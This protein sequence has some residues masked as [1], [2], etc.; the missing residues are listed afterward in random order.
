MKLT[1]DRP[2]T[3][4]QIEVLQIMADKRGTSFGIISYM[5]RSGY[6]KHGIRLA[7][8]TVYSLMK[9]GC[10]TEYKSSDEVHSIT[11][12][13]VERLKAIKDETSRDN[14]SSKEV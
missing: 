6:L 5:G 2:L 4:R 14:R 3:K 10:I 11:D 13:G 12:V 1:P 7:H 8:S 9:S